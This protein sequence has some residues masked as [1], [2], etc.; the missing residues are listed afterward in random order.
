[1]PAAK[2]L[3]AVAHIL[4]TATRSKTKLSKTSTATE[5]ATSSSS[6][7]VRPL[8]GLPISLLEDDDLPEDPLAMGFLLE[9]DDLDKI[10]ALLLW[11][12]QDFHPKFLLR[13]IH[14]AVLDA[15]IKW[16]DAVIGGTLGLLHTASVAKLSHLID[17]MLLH[18]DGSPKDPDQ[19]LAFMRS[20]ARQRDE[21]IY[22]YNATERVELDENQV[23]SCYQRFGRNLIKHE[24]LPHQKQNKKYHL[25]NKFEGDTH[26]SGFQRSFVDSMLRKSLGDKKVAM[27]I[28]QHGLP[29]LADLRCSFGNTA[30]RGPVLDMGM[31]QSSLD[32]CVQWFTCLANDIVTH[33]S[34]EGFDLQL[35]ASSLNGQER[36]R[37]QT[38]REA[39]QKARDALRLGATLA[40]QRDKGKR[41]YDEMD[42]AEQKTL[43]DYETGRTKK[44]K[45]DSTTPTM[46]PFRC[47]LQIIEQPEDPV[48]TVTMQDLIGAAKPKTQPK[49]K[50]I[51][52]ARTKTTRH[53][54]EQ[55]RPDE[56]E[57]ASKTSRKSCY[58]AYALT[59]VLEKDTIIVSCGM[60]NFEE[61]NLSKGRS[62][63]FGQFCCD[64]L[65]DSKPWSGF[66]KGQKSHK[67][68]EQ[69]FEKSFRANFP[70]ICRDRNI[71]IIDCTRIK[72]DPGE[73]KSL[74][75]HCGRHWKNVQNHVD[76]KDFVDLNSPLKELRI[77]KKNLVI[78]VCVQGRHRSVAN[79]ECQRMLISRM[80]NG[81]GS[82]I[83]M[84][85]LQSQSHWR[86]LCKKECEACNM[87]SKEFLAAENKAYDL[88][89]HYIPLPKQSDFAAE[90]TA[91]DL[92]ENQS[93]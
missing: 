22:H 52:V 86:N 42:D 75:G 40:K 30:F 56:N 48:E 45:L 3:S 16:G 92:L 65:G 66:L 83:E 79:K 84:I 69:L 63:E 44:A 88:L 43:E 53:A 9:D 28:W 91:Y 4:L 57:P 85:D 70:D 71:V 18:K 49:T 13:D 19:T 93:R 87:K 2:S 90:N 17:I 32:E 46:Q 51:L 54:T 7:S 36:Q 1:M 61:S 14:H 10:V 41:T 27:L 73:D 50:V 29:R 81:D 72:A 68:T 59:D 77:D 5:H 82:P 21:Q 33:Q 80:Y 26:L 24:L 76:H 20:C 15:V 35:S 55:L 37:Q 74:R 78:N 67:N 62:H 47:K 89:K 8:T 39:L 38:R 12:S 58:N 31:L 60:L 11:M 34:Q 25:R 6:S 64:K 23:S